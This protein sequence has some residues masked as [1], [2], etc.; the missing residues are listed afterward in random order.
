MKKLTLLLAIFLATQSQAQWATTHNGFMF[1][2]T[3]NYH[4]YSNQSNYDAPIEFYLNTNNNT[5][6][7]VYTTGR[8]EKYYSRNNG[9]SIEKGRT[10]DG[11]KFTIYAFYDYVDNKRIRFQIFDKPTS[12]GRQAVRILYSDGYIEFQE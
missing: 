11:S 5:L 7:I 6:E 12:E 9:Y 10:R 3:F 8:T 4:S 2:S 1:K